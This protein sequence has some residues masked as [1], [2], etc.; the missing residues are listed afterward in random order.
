M[1]FTLKVNLPEVLQLALSYLTD[2]YQ[3]QILP[4]VPNGD[5][6]YSL[7]KDIVNVDNSKKRGYVC[8]KA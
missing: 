6:G 7:N 8:T 1:H 3:A 5:N 2:K 4:I